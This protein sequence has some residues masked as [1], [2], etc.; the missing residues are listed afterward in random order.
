MCDV[1]VVIPAYNA[2]WCLQRAIRS[3]LSQ[4]LTPR[5]IIVVDDGST[6]ETPEIALRFSPAVRLIRQPNRGLSAARNTGIRHARADWV[7]FLDA[8]DRWLGAK[9]EAQ[10]AALVAKPHA[11]W[12]FCDARIVNARGDQLGRWTFPTDVET[13]RDLL[14]RLFSANIVAGSGSGVVARRSCLIDA[15]LFD[16]NLRSVED[17]DMWMRLAARYPFAHAPGEHVAITRHAASMSRNLDVMRKHLLAVRWKNRLLL[18]RTPN[19]RRL[20][21]RAYAG[22]L[23]DTGKTA[24]RHDIASHGARDLIESA[25]RSPLAMGPTSIDIL[26]EW[27][28]GRWPPRDH[29]ASPTDTAAQNERLTAV[30]EAPA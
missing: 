26:L 15:G 27:L 9:L 16:E 1:S 20:W 11:H 29:L 12:V 13:Q 14:G 2:A 19:A 17:L 8:D 6:D 30:V 10:T 18:G 22:V 28:I 5:E 7:G 21:N 24:L 3:V 4:T 25:I 23:C